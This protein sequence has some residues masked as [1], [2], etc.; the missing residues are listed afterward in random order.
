MTAVARFW[1]KVDTTAGMDGCWP[2]TASRNRGGYGHFDNTSAHRFSLEL[3]LGR[4]I[5]PGL[6]ACHTCDNPPCCNPAHLF[7]GTHQDN[8]DDRQAKGRGATG[9]HVPAER[10]A[11]GDRHPART[12]PGWAQGSSNGRH[13]LTEDEVRTIRQRLAA[14][15]RWLDIAT[16]FG[17]SKPTV[18]HIAAGRTWQHVQ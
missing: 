7:E 4:P 15:V 18:S 6:F 10:R 2:W 3:K 17:V 1:S 12:T 8:V 11:R 16:E 14:H 9:D 13:R 5:R